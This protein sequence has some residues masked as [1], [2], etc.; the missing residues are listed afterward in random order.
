MASELP[1]R[2]RRILAGP[3]YLT[4]FIFHLLCASLTFLAAKIAGDC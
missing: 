4:A 2:V 1:K 3:F